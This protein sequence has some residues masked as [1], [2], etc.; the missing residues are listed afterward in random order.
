MGALIMNNFEIK[1]TKKLARK[2]T[3]LY[4]GTASLGEIKNWDLKNTSYQL[5]NEIIQIHSSKINVIQEQK[6]L[7]SLNIDD[8]YLMTVLPDTYLEDEYPVLISN[9]SQIT[10]VINSLLEIEIFKDFIE[11]KSDKIS[12]NSTK[13]MTLRTLEKIITI[14]FERYTLEE[15]GLIIKNFIEY[16]EE[17]INRNDYYKNNSVKSI[18]NLKSKSIINSSISWYIIFKFFLENY[19]MNVYK[20]QNFPN[21]E[22]NITLYN[23]NGNFFDKENPLWDKVFLSKRKFYPTRENLEKAYEIWLEYL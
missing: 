19:K 15:V 23:W 11:L 13:I 9:V 20:Y 2:N 5:K 12:N 17:V 1:Q 14:L 8:G 6:S 7:Y 3:E 21:L 4:L 16:V 18:Q 10:F 22:L